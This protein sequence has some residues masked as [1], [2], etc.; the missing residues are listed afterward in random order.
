MTTVAR[1]DRC[2]GSGLPTVPS[3]YNDDRATCSVCT[4]HLNV[5]VTVAAPPHKPAVGYRRVTK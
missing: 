4:K 5:L 1:R 3:R 2:E